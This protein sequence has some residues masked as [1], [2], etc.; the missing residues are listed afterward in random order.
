MFAGLGLRINNSTLFCRPLTDYRWKG[1]S[2]GTNT[3]KTSADSG[4][5]TPVVA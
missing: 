1:K 4:T 2:P 5:G 3:E